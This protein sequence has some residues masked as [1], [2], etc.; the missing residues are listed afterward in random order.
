MHGAD[1][2]TMQRMPAKAKDAGSS[3]RSGAPVRTAGSNGVVAPQEQS[4]PDHR[5]DAAQDIVR[6]VVSKTLTTSS[7]CGLENS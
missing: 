3:P 1:C 6:G 2:L 7:H 5:A 4:A